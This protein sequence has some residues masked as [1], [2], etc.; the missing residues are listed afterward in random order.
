MQERERLYRE[1]Q[2]WI[3]RD[4]QTTTKNSA[5]LSGINKHQHTSEQSLH[6]RSSD[7]KHRAE[8]IA[9]LDQQ[10]TQVTD[11]SGNR[12]VKCEKCGLIDTDDK[13]ASYGGLNRIN[14]GICYN[15]SGIRRPI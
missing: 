9:L 1:H 15:C 14:L 10:Q 13:F 5:V 3:K 8:V 6:F 2:E 7:D 11:S 12:W 4:Q